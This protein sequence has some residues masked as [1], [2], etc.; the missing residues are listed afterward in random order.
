MAEKTRVCITLIC[1]GC[2]KDIE[3]DCDGMTLHFETV[4]EAR[5]RVNDDEDATCSTAGDFCG[6][7]KLDPHPYIPHADWPDQ[8]GRCHVDKDDHEPAGEVR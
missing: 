1:D 8:C 7:C 2:G 3:I 4:E 6:L 5:Q